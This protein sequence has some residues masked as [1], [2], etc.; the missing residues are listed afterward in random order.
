MDDP[1]NYTFSHIEI[2]DY[3]DINPNSKGWMT[4]RIGGISSD[5]QDRSQ[6]EVVYYDKEDNKNH[7][8]C[9]NTK[10]INDIAPFGTKC[11]NTHFLISDE[12][13]DHHYDAHIVS[14]DNDMAKTFGIKYNDVPI[15]SQLIISESKTDFSA[16][17]ANIMAFQCPKYDPMVTEFADDFDH[18]GKEIGDFVHHLLFK[19][20]VHHSHQVII[21]R[22]QSIN[23][24][25]PNP[26]FF[27][28][29]QHLNF[30][31]D[32]KTINYDH[33]Y[34]TKISLLNDLTNSTTLN[35]EW[36][37]ARLQKL[38]NSIIIECDR[39]IKQKI[40]HLYKDKMREKQLP[41]FIHHFYPK[42]HNIFIETLESVYN[43]MKI[44]VPK[45]ITQDIVELM[46]DENENNAMFYD[47]WFLQRNVNKIAIPKV[48]LW[49]DLLF[50]NKC[51]KLT[52]NPYNGWYKIWT[53][54]EEL[55]QNKE[56][57]ISDIILQMRT[58]NVLNVFRPIIW[59]IFLEIN[60][61]NKRIYY[62]HEYVAQC[63]DLSIKDGYSLKSV[64]VDIF[65][66]LEDILCGSKYL[67]EFM[68]SIQY[69]FG[70]NILDAIYG[71]NEMLSCSMYKYD[72]LFMNG[73]RY[74]THLE[75]RIN[76]IH[77]IVL[78]DIYKLIKLSM[79]DEEFEIWRAFEHIEWFDISLKSYLMDNIFF[80]GID[81]MV[82]G[83]AAFLEL[84]ISDVLNTFQSEGD[85]EHEGL[86]LDLLSFNDVESMS[87]LYV[88]YRNKL[89]NSRTNWKHFI[90]GTEII[91]AFI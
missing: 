53:P 64:I 49:N 38:I 21:L 43:M 50:N 29:R 32:D 56:G 42:T 15:K 54:S 4:G 63:A 52:T 8:Y 22:Y 27:Q 65:E 51:Y 87:S 72:M 91:G 14:M 5:L 2:N 89:V 7:S 55:L 62:D 85:E 80:D 10:N 16:I 11:D 3:V 17:I 41:L 60:P 18:I 71:L 61:L 47:C 81:A 79:D 57:G 33:E 25:I 74:Q 48:T 31:K 37:I 75:R 82:I 59:S 39:N 68:V 78:P 86:T 1:L 20:F 66:P 83:F 84:K 35:S 77:P 67:R 70:G 28:I 88:E 30:D 24:D 73:F 46:F 45:E 6:F 13:L 34:I 69:M 44:H 90:K 58:N 12:C 40:H 23:D 19:D 36:S 26:H 9:V 76:T